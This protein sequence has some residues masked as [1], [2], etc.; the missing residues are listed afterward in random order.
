MAG[1]LLDLYATLSIDTSG[2]DKGMNDAEKRAT[3][4][5]N[6]SDNTGKKVQKLGPM[7]VAA[8][9]LIAS[10]L[11]KAGSAMTSMGKY[12]ISSSIDAETSFAKV[13]T[14][15]DTTVVSSEDME[16]AIVGL[17]SQFGVSVGDISDSVY[18]VISATGDTANAVSLVEKATMLA[19]GGFAETGDAVSVLTTAINAYGLSMEDA[20][21]ISD[22]LITVQNLGV[23]TVGELSSQ[24]GKAIA[25]GAAYG[26][27]L[28]NLETGYIALTKAGIGT[29]ES[30]TYMSSMMNELGDSGSDVA[31][32][33]QE[34]TG[35]S[36]GQLMEDGT[37]LGDVLKIL[38]DSCNGDSEAFMN[39]WGS[40][41]AGK[42]A[43]A[44]AGQGFEEFNDW[45]TQVGESAGATETAYKQMSETTAEKIEQLK[46][47][48]TNLG[49][50]AIEPIRAKIEEFL[51][52]VIEMIQSVDIDAV[53]EKLGSLV[54]VIE[55]VAVAI[56]V[57]TAGI[58]AY[59]IVQGIKL[60]M[61]AAEVTTLGGLIAAEAGAAAATL[62]AV[63]PFIAVAAAIAGAIAIGVLIVKNWDEIKAKAVEL[64][65]K[66]AE[67]WN[68]FTQ[69]TAEFGGKVIDK[70]K[71]VWESVTEKFDG[72]KT[73]F[74]EVMKKPGEL[75]DE[76]KETFGSISSFLS[77]TIDDILDLFDFDWSFPAPKLPHIAWHWEDISVFGADIMSYPSF[78]GIEWY[79]KA[80]DAGYMFNS[81]TI[82][83]GK[84]FGDAGAEMVIG[85][86]SMMD[87]ISDAQSEGMNNVIN[88]LLRIVDVMESYFP[89]F[90][91]KS[92]FSYDDFVNNTAHKMGNRIKEIDY[93][94]GY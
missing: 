89:E 87:M 71:E 57:V 62:A 54:P 11:K 76:I 39:L 81:P 23:T 5:G 36:F 65:G 64:A 67:K 37:S 69:A 48:F 7:T 63:A 84:G 28:E 70:V 19:K 82:L 25:T 24:M 31:G 43:S 14:I 17:S 80:M 32:I 60:A 73:A 52:K 3:Q 56:G 68:E 34:K 6:T 88:V 77:D 53:Y 59:N 91:D 22:S 55:G 13:G 4:F 33:L 46:T 45:L 10:G 15:M 92:G 12:A 94:G 20:E 42:A 35:K 49:T 29:A 90:A 50:E 93:V 44:I 8:G 27:N 83:G 1:S 66:V 75:W 30:T 16:K 9:N 40:A 85:R 79:A 2:Y 86:D 26:V 47:S 72:I 41:E 61:E 18:N 58:T 78:D 74:D 21:H 51:P 38:Y